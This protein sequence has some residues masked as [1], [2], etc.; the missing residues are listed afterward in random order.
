M[1]RFIDMDR[2]CRSGEHVIPAGTRQCGPC[3][4]LAAARRAVHGPT[5]K[6]RRPTA[7]TAKQRRANHSAY[8]RQW[9]ADHFGP[10][11]WRRRNLR[12]LYNLTPEAFEAIR[13]AQFSCCALCAAP[14]TADDP[15]VVD[16]DHSTGR[17][18][19]LLHRGCNRML[20][21]FGDDPRRM[22][23]LATAYAASVEARDAERAAHGPAADGDRSLIDEGCM[24]SVFFDGY[25]CLLHRRGRR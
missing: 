6:H 24:C 10:A 8:M 22:A 16:H 19:G 23:I 5:R 15:P 4:D 7:K 13:D 25:V 14:F 17:V 11:D 20:A 12:G 9:R 2:P 3:R 21:R 1:N 18:R